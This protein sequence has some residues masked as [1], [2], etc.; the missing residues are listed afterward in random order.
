MA[1]VM[2]QITTAEQRSSPASLGLRLCLWE[3]LCL[4]TILTPSFPSP[5]PLLPSPAEMHCSR[6]NLYEEGSLGEQSS[7]VAIWHLSLNVSNADV[8]TK[9]I[10]M[11]ILLLLLIERPTYLEE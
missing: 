5:P 8:N 11:I 1:G 10:I 6:L 7:S 3:S 9:L 4:Y 2:L